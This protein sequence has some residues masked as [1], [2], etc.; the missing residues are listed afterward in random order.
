MPSF[1]RVSARERQKIT[2]ALTQRARAP[3]RRVQPEEAVRR[4][5]HGDGGQ[6]DDGEDD[7]PHRLD[8][9][10]GQR[11]GQAANVKA[12]RHRLQPGDVLNWENG[13]QQHAGAHD[14]LQGHVKDGRHVIV[15]GRAL[16]RVVG[17]RRDDA[18]G[19][20]GE[21][22]GALGERV[23]GVDDDHQDARNQVGQVLDDAAN[24]GPRRVGEHRHHEVQR[25]AQAI[26][27][28]EKVDDGADQ[29]ALKARLV[30]GR[31]AKLAGEVGKVALRPLLLGRVL[32]EAVE[33]A[34]GEF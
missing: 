17:V 7:D 4:L 3:V 32:D 6:R 33:E 26:E 34:R 31:I 2:L 13:A 20:V 28:L 14:H 23:D 18:I 8:Q 11:L 1:A 29:I 5:R 25:V 22:V 30:E 12:G 24:V 21:P 16:E 10:V 27:N 19:K 9:R 15:E